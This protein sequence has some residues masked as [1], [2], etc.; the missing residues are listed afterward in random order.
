MDTISGIIW[1]IEMEDEDARDRDRHLKEIAG[2]P[3]TNIT[4]F[5]FPNM[6][7]YISVYCVTLL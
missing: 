5:R 2:T 7:P 6:F 3:N 1:N 4:F